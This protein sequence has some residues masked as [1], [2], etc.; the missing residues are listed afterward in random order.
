MVAPIEDRQ[1]Y[2][3]ETQRE[4]L[5]ALL[6]EVMI[7]ESFFLTGGTALSVFYLHHRRSEDID[8]FTLSLQS[9]NE[10]SLWVKRTWADGVAVC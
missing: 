8:L 1:C 4:I 5:M 9:L 2:A 6:S 3:S 10:I 7:G